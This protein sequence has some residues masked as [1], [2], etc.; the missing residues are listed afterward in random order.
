MYLCA[1]Y[2]PTGRLYTCNKIV[3]AEHNHIIGSNTSIYPQT[4]RN[5][6]TLTSHI[7]MMICTVWQLSNET[8]VIECNWNK[9]L[10]YFLYFI[11]STPLL[12]RYS[13]WHDLAKTG[14]TSTRL[15]VV[16]AEDSMSQLLGCL[17]H[18]QKGALSMVTSVWGTENNHRGDKSAE[19][20][21]W[22]STH[23]CFRAKNS[24]TATARWTGALSWRRNQL[25]GAEY[26]GRTWRIRFHRRSRTLK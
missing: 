21:G 16:W 4:W 7:F 8:G 10:E 19:Q 14:R 24:C 26:S 2:R 13:E 6:V 18:L 25:P 3:F 20:C 23:T 17:E 9:R 12:H 22:W 15:L 1:V 5:A 11:Q